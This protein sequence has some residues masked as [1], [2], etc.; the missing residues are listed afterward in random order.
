MTE[1]PHP[2]IRLLVA[3]SFELVQMGLRLLLENH[4][5]VDLVADTHRMGDLLNLAAQH[6]P[7]VILIDLQLNSGNCLE[8]IPELLSASPQS[9]L[10]AFTHLSNNHPHLQTF[11]SGATGI[12]GKHHSC[13]LLLKAIHAI[14]AGQIWFD[15]HITQLPLQTQFDSNPS[16]EIQTVAITSHQPGL[17]NSERCIASLACKG[18]SAREIGLQLSITEKTV[19]NKLSEIYKKNRRKEAN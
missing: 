10:L 18:L 11:C 14:H 6:K 1:S 3:E 8:Y 15:R 19:R 16:R 12:I 9:K 13:E 7:D 2:G 17:T 5:T 4:P